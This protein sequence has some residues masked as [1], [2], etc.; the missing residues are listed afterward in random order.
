MVN[1]SCKICGARIVQAERFL[2]ERL[3]C[4]KKCKLIMYALREAKKI[5]R[6]RVMW[7]TF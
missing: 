6:G 5:M 1:G 7:K 2:K 4:S 3:Y